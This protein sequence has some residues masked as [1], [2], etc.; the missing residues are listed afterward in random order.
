MKSQ[1]KNIRDIVYFDFIQEINLYV[2][3]SDY[4]YS[5]WS[6]LGLLYNLSVDIIHD[7]IK[8]EILN[9]TRF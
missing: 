4:G 5:S 3:F 9:K 2:S 6:K 8:P 7:F 1:S